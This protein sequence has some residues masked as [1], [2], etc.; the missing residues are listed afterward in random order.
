MP[1]LSPGHRSGFARLYNEHQF[2]HENG[3]LVL[4]EKDFGRQ[5]RAFT[6]GFSALRE[7]EHKRLLDT[8][9]YEKLPF[10]ETVS[11]TAEWRMRGYDLAVISKLLG[12][13][14]PERVLDVGAWNGSLSPP[15][16]ARPSRDR[17]RLFY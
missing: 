10:A 4:L 1:E 6:A 12:R 8:S 3:V 11:G 9:A 13:R 14:G 7:A 15:R 16:G 17:C 2:A 5:L